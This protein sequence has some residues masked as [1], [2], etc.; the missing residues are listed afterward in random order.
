MKQ[1]CIPEGYVPSAAVAVCCWGGGLFRG[2][3]A[4]GSEPGRG[5]VFL[6]C[7]AD[8][9]TRWT[10]FLTHVC[11]TLPFRNFVFY[12]NWKRETSNDQHKL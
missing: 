1:E 6:V 4:L 9:P 3:S 10:E 2:V 12:E 5:V 7:L 11:E 8:T